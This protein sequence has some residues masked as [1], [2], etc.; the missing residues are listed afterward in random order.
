MVGC[1]EGWLGVLKGWV[2]CFKR[3]LGVLR[4][5]WVFQAVVGCFEGVVGCFEGV[6]WVLF[7]LNS[8]L[9]LP[10]HITPTTSTTPHQP[11]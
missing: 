5:G 8:S 3:W 6:G 11:H 2:G 7:H 1:F 10:H 9:A 4:G